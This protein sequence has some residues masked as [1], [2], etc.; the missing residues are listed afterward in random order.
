[1]ATDWDKPRRVD[2]G[3]QGGQNL[4]LRLVQAAYEALRRALEDGAIRWHT[5]PSEDSEVAVDLG[6]VVFVRLDTEQ[7][8]VGF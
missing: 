6:Q 4:T 5:V 8:K 3:F 1:M 7:H 2:I